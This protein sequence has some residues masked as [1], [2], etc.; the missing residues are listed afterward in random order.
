LLSFIRSNETNFDSLSSFQMP[1]NSVQP[2]IQISIMNFDINQNKKKKSSNAFTRNLAALRPFTDVN[3]RLGSCQIDF[4]IS[5][6]DRIYSLKNAFQ[7][8]N[9]PSEQ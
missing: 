5:I 1:Y 8:Y 3:I 9:S 6:I 7:G 2:S 4:D